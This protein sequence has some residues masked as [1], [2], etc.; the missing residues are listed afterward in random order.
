MAVRRAASRHVPLAPNRWVCIHPLSKMLE[1][2]SIELFRNSYTPDFFIKCFSIVW[3]C[4]GCS[5]TRDSKLRVIYL[6]QR[7][8]SRKRSVLSRCVVRFVGSVFGSEQADGNFWGVL[9]FPGR[10][11]SRGSYGEEK[12]R[13][14]LF[15]VFRVH[16]GAFDR[17]A[18]TRGF[19]HLWKRG[20]QL[21]EEFAASHAVKSR[22]T[23][24]DK[25]L[26]VLS[27]LWKDRAIPAGHS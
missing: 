20:S 12:R 13:N 16:E 1:F 4:R 25:K 9:T 18:R 24:V 6:I 7:R 21:S 26:R 2:D 19:L 11:L 14:V 22:G 23:P 8:G 3:K 27:Q 15:E 5:S 17:V 10:R